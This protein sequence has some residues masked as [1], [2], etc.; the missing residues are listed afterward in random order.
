VEK[1]GQMA[2]NFMCI[3]VDM[4]NRYLKLQSPMVNS[5]ETNKTFV[6]RVKNR[7]RMGEIPIKMNPYKI[8]LLE[9]LPGFEGCFSIKRHSVP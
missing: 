6:S 9:T 8:F 2:E 3:V 4:N 5:M 1:P 7:R